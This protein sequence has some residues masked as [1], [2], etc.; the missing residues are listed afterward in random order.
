M[1]RGSSAGNRLAECQRRLANVAGGTRPARCLD[2]T[3][4]PLAFATGSLLSRAQPDPVFRPT[5]PAMIHQD[6]VAPRDA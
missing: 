1:R 3:T 4:A 6:H 5:G 2:V